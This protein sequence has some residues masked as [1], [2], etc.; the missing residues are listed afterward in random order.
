MK[1][2]WKLPDDVQCLGMQLEERKLLNAL[3][4]LE[5][6]RLVTKLNSSSC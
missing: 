3:S 5:P 4:Q 1:E 2:S 6:W